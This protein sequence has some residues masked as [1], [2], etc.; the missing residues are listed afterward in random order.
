MVSRSS[1]PGLVLCAML[2]LLGVSG[3]SEA[4]EARSWAVVGGILS[5]FAEIGGD[6]GIDWGA[7]E[8][9]SQE[10]SADCLLP[11]EQ[12]RAGGFSAELCTSRMVSCSASL[13][14][15]ET[16]SVFEKASISH[17]EQ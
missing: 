1:W 9:V 6:P 4:R 10:T 13:E 11:L 17:S 7:S 2:E 15:E 12:R 16:Q 14:D 5:S 8:W 3:C